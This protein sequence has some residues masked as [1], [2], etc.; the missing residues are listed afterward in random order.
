ML[1]LFEQYRPKRIEDVVG[2]DEAVKTL[3]FIAKRGYVGRVFWITGKS[4]T[5]KTTLARI[6]A[7][8]V[9]QSYAIVEIDAAD[10]SIDRVRQYE[11]WCRMKP[12]GCEAHAFII[13]EAHSLRPAILARLNTTFEKPEVLKNS[14]W[15]FTTTLDGHKRL[16]DA[17]EI[18][19]VPF[20]SR[21]IQLS[22]KSDENVT[23][24]FAI[25]ARNAA[26]AEGMD[27]RPLD[28]YVKLV[29]K[30]NHNLREVFQ[31][32]D[33]GVMCQNA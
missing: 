28:E 15:C 26:Q 23:L 5:G 14:T 20:G 17:E 6:I 9:A 4:G 21:T 25:R 13:N 30:H 3:Q 10:L 12:I 22:L 27:G 33:A 29:R 19:T 16:F 31:A 1:P 7:K 8:T 18:E 24:S 2:Q 11:D 32:I